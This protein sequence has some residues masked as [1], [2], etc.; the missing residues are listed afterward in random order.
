MSRSRKK[1]PIDALAA[2]GQKSQQKWKKQCRHKF[3]RLPI[4]EDL[5]NGSKYK[6]M[7]GNIW[8]SPSDGKVWRE[9]E[10]AYRK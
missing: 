9:D 8:N 7:S 6:I 3:R 1:H 5:P 2:T 10:K 4:D